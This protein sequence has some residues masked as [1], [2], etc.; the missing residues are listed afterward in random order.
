MLFKKFNFIQYEFQS[1]PSPH[2]L[3]QRDDMSA[4]DVSSGFEKW[5]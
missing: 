2:V 1:Y 3:F 4:T 5:S